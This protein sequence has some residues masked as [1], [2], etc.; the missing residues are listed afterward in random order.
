MIVK[1]LISGDSAKAELKMANLEIIE[2]EKKVNL[3]DSVINTMKAKETNY[4][5]IISKKDEKYSILENH[6]KKIQTELKKRKVM[7][8]FKSF[9]SVGVIGVLSFLLITK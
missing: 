8:K 2:L 3:K 6:T 7:N 9:I 5:E 1:D 4:I